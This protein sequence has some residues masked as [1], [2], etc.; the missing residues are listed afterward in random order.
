MKTRRKAQ[1]TCAAS[2][3][4]LEDAAYIDGANPFTMVIRVMLPLSLPILVVV[5]L[6]TAVGHWN[7]WFD[8]MIF[9]RERNKMVL[10]LLLRRILIENSDETMK[11]LYVFQSARPLTPATVKAATIMV[12]VIPILLAYPFL[13]KYFVKGV[14]IGSIKE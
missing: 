13:Q 2:A 10:Q 9:V 12:S 7:S 14:L 1:T 11:Q 8:A 6:W 5:A 4:E 3:T